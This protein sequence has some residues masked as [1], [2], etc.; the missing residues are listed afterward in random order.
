MVKD[1]E[2]A[3][4]T[5]ELWEK[6]NAVN[7]AT[8]QKQYECGLISKDVF[9]KISSM[10]KFYI[11]LRGF[12]ETTSAEAYAYLN[13]KNSAF[14]APIKKAMGRSS[15]ADNP[16]ANMQ[17]MA[18]SAIMQ[19]NRNKLVKQRFLNFILNHPS[20]LVSINKLWLGYDEVTEEWRPVFPDNIYTDDE[21]Y[22]VE[23]K[24]LQFEK[25]MEGLAKSNPEKYKS[26]ED[27][28]DIP[29]RV[30]PIDLREHQVLVK[31]NGVDYILTVNGSPRL[32]QALNGLTNPDNDISGHIGKILKASEWINRQL[33][34]FYTTRN[35]DFVLSNFLRDMLY[36]N[37]MAWIKESPNYALKFHA[38]VAKFNPV[39]MR[40][41]YSKYRDGILDMGNKD[42]AMF[43]YFIMNGGE[44][45]YTN[46]RDIEKHKKDIEKELKSTGKITARKAMS[47]LAMQLDELNRSV[48]N[49]ARFAAFVTSR[50]MGRSLDRA[51]YDAKEISV[52]FN[53]K[54]SGSTFL[55]AEGQ[56]KIG[57]FS[58]FTSGAGRS[59]YV[60]WN[61]AVQGTTNFGRQVKRHPAKAFTGAAAMFVL[62][63]L[64]ASIGSGDDD[65]KNAYYNLP[66]YVRRTNIMVRVGDSWIS[67]PL[68]IEYRA[69]Y[70]LGE[71]CAS[72]TSGKEHFSDGELGWAVLGQL[73]QVLPIDVLEGGGGWNAFVPT[74]A[75][76]EVE[77]L[78]NRSWSG[79]PIYKDTPYN[80]NMP[81]WTKAY[82]SANKYLVNLSKTLNEAT[83]GDNYTPGAIDINPAQIEY[84][85][86]GYFSGVTGT[87]DK[88]TKMADT[89]FGDREYDHRDWIFLN[90]IL[91]TGD[92]R[93]EYR[94]VN[95]EYSRLMK[96]VL[97]TKQRMRGYT[98]D[99]N[100]GIV[101]YAEKLVFLNNSPE[102]QRA[103]LF[104]AYNKEINSLDKMLDYPLTK[105]QG[106]A[107]ESAINTLKSQLVQAANRTRE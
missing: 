92:E 58:A 49:C 22:E 3:H 19:G 95:K 10:Y 88:M 74:W 32:A 21:P 102:Y 85:L 2:D 68:P 90:R 86:K 53:K 54:G 89:M 26:G 59:F 52:N 61:A 45:G 82:K 28:V 94:A 29:Y 12:K 55:D 7:K 81:E 24:M 36:T 70:G 96:E 48:E 41:L 84:I 11:P 39:T 5:V 34:A 69:I 50:E 104:D 46:I 47:A 57:N 60:F 17:S 6:V 103:L 44:T 73:S 99:A 76:P 31:R 18:E 98:R 105:E 1:Y 38:N 9:D 20:D 30:L 42:E 71:L 37:T 97:L 8:L 16:F 63:Y 56:T 101:E 62:G 4:D 79:L 65:D 40:L 64:M 66:E 13:H 72:A 43:Y 100:N 107:V 75:K 91:K 35:P 77:A 25:K 80:K 33:S 78:A 15:K 14:N 27:A 106:K 51:I 83:G 93:T 87:I 67:I 23:R